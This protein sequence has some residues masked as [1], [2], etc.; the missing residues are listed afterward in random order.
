VSGI[1]IKKTDF[2][3]ELKVTQK[4]Y[5]CLAGCAEDTEDAKEN[6][7]NF[8]FCWNFQIPLLIL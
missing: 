7:K 5:F 8:N 3:C 2:P 6:R 1:L 4:P